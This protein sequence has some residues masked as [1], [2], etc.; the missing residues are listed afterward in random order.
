M[1]KAAINIKENI[2][3]GHFSQVVVLLKR[4]ADGFVAKKSKILTKQ[5]IDK[6]LKE[7]DDQIYLAVKVVLIAGIFGASR[8]DE[9]VKMTFNDIEDFGSCIKIVVPDTK[10]NVTRQFIVTAGDIPEMSMV[11]IVRKYLKLRPEKLS[12]PRMFIGYRN[13]KCM[14]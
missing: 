7:A 14:A 8:R 5:Q 3:I 13:G 9:L 6:F 4:K 11:D 12:S 2:N 10:T 1:L